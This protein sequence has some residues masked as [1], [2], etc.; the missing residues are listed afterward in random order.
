MPEPKIRSLAELVE[1]DVRRGEMVLDPWLPVCG[2]AMIAGPTGLG[3]TQ[4]AL[5]CAM[6]IAGGGRVLDWQAGGARGVL[7]VDGEMALADMQDRARGLLAAANGDLEA[8]SQNLHFFCDSDQETGI[9]NLIA[10]PATRTLIERVL[11]MLRAEV[12]ILDNLSCLCNAEDENATESWVVMQEW[13]LR[14]RRKGYTVIFLHHTGKPSFNKEGEV[15]VKQRGTSKREDVL[16]S[17]MILKPAGLN[18]FQIE[19]TKHRGFV[20]DPELFGNLVFTD[21]G[22]C[23]VRGDQKKVPLETIEA[24]AAASAGELS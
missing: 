4:L 11:I 16:N 24:I 1:A 20:P 23:W 18:R 10:S 6:A 17:T 14:L 8:I 13:L 5:A 21:D 9:A 2:L 15:F 3:K 7:Y 12:L 19:F 22:R